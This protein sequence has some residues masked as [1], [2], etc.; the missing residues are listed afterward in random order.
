M[1]GKKQK[2]YA[3]NFP[4][5]KKRHE[6]SMVKQPKIASNT[7]D[8]KRCCISKTEGVPWGYSENENVEESL[9]IK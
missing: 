9:P 1:S 2:I 5:R 6:N 8:N 7:L 4:F 3:I